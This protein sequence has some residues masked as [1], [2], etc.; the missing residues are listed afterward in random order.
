MPAVEQ[1]MD[2][3]GWD[4][5][6]DR[7]TPRSVLDS[8][9]IRDHLWADFVVTADDWE[10]GELSDADL[11]SQAV[12]R[13]VYLG[14]GRDRTSLD[15]EGLEFL[16]GTSGDGGELY[17]STD[18]TSSTKDFE[19]QLDD[20][21]FARANGITKGSVI[22]T[23]ATTFNL[24][25][26]GGDTARETLDTAC[27]IAPGGPNYWRINLDLT[28]DA[29][30]L[31]TL[32]PTAT[33]PTVIL[34]DAGGPEGALDGFAAELDMD[35]LDGR[36]VR[37]NVQVDWNDGTNNGTASPTLP[38]T[39]RNP[40]GGAMVQRALIDW[41]PKRPRPPT[42]RWRKVAAWG[43]KSQGRAN[44]LAA[45][46][47]NERAVIREELTAT[48]PDLVVPWRYDLTP[49][50]TVYV[51]DLDLDLINTANEVYYRGEAC[52]PTTGRVDEMTSPFTEDLG[53]WLRVYDGV[54]AF[55]WVHLTRYVVPEEGPVELMINQRSRF[56]VRAK[57][58][59]ITAKQRQGWYGYA[60]RQK[61]LQDFYDS[62]S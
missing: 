14:Q 44:Q 10:P 20:R 47:A 38:A 46:E 40:A 56:P 37:S 26:E 22:D 21:V 34:T 52:H 4:L 57:A 39:Y 27:R 12:Y 23:T 42:E 24:G 6:L 11:L 17:A 33:T 2:N 13:G 7:R 54:S 29:D 62:L 1:L 60:L 9:D 41:R 31:A 59:K 8:I 15:G 35:G 3:G 5:Q 48:L 61:R 30:D 50:N 43:I 28:L 58:R 45:A 51:D 18:F 16:L 19:L 32:W 55:D 49:G 25:I 53:Y 36:E